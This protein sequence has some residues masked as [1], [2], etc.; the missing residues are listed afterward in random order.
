M[1]RLCN[2]EDIPERESRA[3]E[4]HL[5]EIF[6]TQRDGAFFAYQNIC[7]H[8]GTNLEYME[9]EYLDM[10]KEYIIC[11]THGALFQVDSGLCVF[12]PCQGDSLKSVKISVH[13]DGGIYL[14]E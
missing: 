8:L 12:G 4:T 13:S 9:N 6:I 11:S 5:G 1:Q 3:F 2:T 14:D 7:P 10:D